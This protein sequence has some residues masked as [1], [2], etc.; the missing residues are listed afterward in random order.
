MKASEQG[1]N[2]PGAGRYRAIPRTLIFVTSRNPQSGGRDVLLLKGAPTKRLWPNRYNGLGGHVEAGEDVLSAARRELAEEAGITPAALTLRGIINIHTGADAQG[3]RPACSS[4]SSR[5]ARG[6]RSAPP[7]K[8]RP[9][10]CPSTPWRTTWSTICGIIRALDEA[11]LL[12]HY[13]PSGWFAR[14]QF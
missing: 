3:P 7:P 13:A 10:G 1:V 6:G 4:S 14:Y 11:D 12:R 8:E 5:R 9:N 2:E